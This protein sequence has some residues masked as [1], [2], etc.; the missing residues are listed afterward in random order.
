MDAER[1]N[2]DIECDVNGYARSLCERADED[3]IAARL[4][5]FHDLTG[6]FLWNGQQCIEKYLKAIALFQDIDVRKQG[7]DLKKLFTKIDN[8]LD[9]KSART[10]FPHKIEGIVSKPE[11]YE[12]FLQRLTFL[13]MNRYC[14]HSWCLYGDE[15]IKLDAAVFIIRR[16]CT[17]IGAV[18][19]KH[20]R[21][22]KDKIKICIDEG[23]DY[24]VHGHLGEVI[25][26]DKH[27]DKRRYLLEGNSFFPVCKDIELAFHVSKSFNHV[28]GR[29]YE[30]ASMGNDHNKHL[31]IGLAT[32]L[33]QR[34]Y[35]D[36]STESELKADIQRIEKKLTKEAI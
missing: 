28:L 2:T 5:Y 11:T 31:F 4:S 27:I 6:N 7:H 19:G 30:S 25:R 26:N 9:I 1:L 3:Y 22:I 17:P 14:S 20:G 32:K 10:M 29:R 16:Y 23:R 13:G 35:F 24:T 36:K 8:H 33:L 15:L 18:I 12:D 34:L 21:P